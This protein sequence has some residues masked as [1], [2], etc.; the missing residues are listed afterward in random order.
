MF[1]FIAAR[2]RRLAFTWSPKTIYSFCRQ[3]QKTSAFTAYKKHRYLYCFNFICNHIEVEVNRCEWIIL[4]GN[5]HV[6]DS[7]NKEDKDTYENSSFIPFVQGPG[8]GRDIFQSTNIRSSNAVNPQFQFE[9]I[10]YGE[11]PSETK[12]QK[13]LLTRKKRICKALIYC[14]LFLKNFE[15]VIKGINTEFVLFVNNFFTI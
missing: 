3:N 5:F 9:V 1:V 12:Y 4:D 10:W 8:R 11:I 15:T 14:S 7:W 6:I 2:I 13:L